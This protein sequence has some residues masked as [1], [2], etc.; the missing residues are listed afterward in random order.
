M[1]N[2]PT[3]PPVESARVQGQVT[4]SRSYQHRLALVGITYTSL[5]GRR[6]SSGDGFQE[7]HL[8]TPPEECVVL[9]GIRSLSALSPQR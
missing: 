4:E 8:S 5:M 3:A 9:C 6:L 1:P 7:R 2:I